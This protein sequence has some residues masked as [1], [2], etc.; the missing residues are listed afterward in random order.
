MN[1]ITTFRFS[2]ILCAMVLMCQYAIAGEKTFHA[3]ATAKVA[4][5]EG[6]V[7]VTPDE[8]KTPSETDY[9]TSSSASGKVDKDRNASSGD[10]T[11]YLFAK[12]DAGYKFSGWYNEEAC[13]SDVSDKAEAKVAF[14]SKSEK[15]DAPATKDYFAKF[16]RIKYN[17]ELTVAVV[18]GE[19]L[20]AVDK[21]ADAT[22]DYS[23]S[24]TKSITDIQDQH[25]YYIKA[26]ANSHYE[27]V[28]WYSDA[29][30]Q[31]QIAT[32]ENYT[33]S[34]EAT[35]EDEGSTQVY[36]YAKFR[37]ARIYYKSKLTV[38][39][40]GKGQVSIATSADGD[41]IFGTTLTADNEIADVDK[42]K[43]Y[44]NAR[45]N[46]ITHYF[47]GW[48]SDAE[49]KNK[50]SDDAQFAYDVQAVDGEPTGQTVYAKFAEY[51]YNSKIKV[52]ATGKGK[53]FVSKDAE[54][55]ATYTTEMS[56]SQT[57]NSTTQSYHLSALPDSDNDEFE[58]WYKDAECE[59]LISKDA[60]YTHTLTAVL[61]DAGE[62]VLY[63]KFI[64][65]EGQI[66]SKFT[67][68]AIGNGEVFVTTEEN[69][70]AAYASMSSVKKTK[71]IKT[72]Y[73][74]AQAKA[75]NYFV[76][77]YKESE[78]K[79]LLSKDAKYTHTESAAEASAS[80]TNIYAKF[81]DM[82]RS[83]V[84]VETAGNG[85]VSVRDEADGQPTFGLRQ[86]ATQSV[87]DATQVYII[88]ALPQENYTF[89]GWFAD[90]AL[91][92]KIANTAKYEMSVTGTVGKPSETTVYAKFARKESTSKMKAVAVGEGTIFVSE[93][94]SEEPTYTA[95]MERSQSSVADVHTYYF[96]A[97]GGNFRGW[98]ADEACS[99]LLS[100]QKNMEYTI[101]ATGDESEAITLYAKFEAYDAPEGSF[102]IPNSDFELWNK[103]KDEPNPGW[104]SFP[105]AVGSMAGTGKSMSPFPSQEKGRG[106]EGY[107]VK[108]YS[109]Y[110]G[111]MGIGANA[112][113]NLTTGIINMGNMDPED[114]S[115]HNYT[116]VND[117]NHHVIIAGQP[118]AFEF[119]SKFKAGT[120]NSKK[121]AHLQATIHDKYKYIDPEVAANKPHRIAS[122]SINIQESTDWVRNVQPINY[123][124]EWDF[125]KAAAT[126]KYI[127]ATFTTNQIPGGSKDDEL[128]ID[129]VR[130]IYYSEIA[131]AKYN[132]LPLTFVDGMANVKASFDESKLSVVL[133][134]RGA[135]CTQSFNPSEGL[136]TLLV[137]GEDIAVNSENYHVYTVQFNKVLPV[138]PVDTDANAAAAFETKHKDVLCIAPY[139]VTMAQKT[140]INAA[141][142]D[143]AEL[144]DRA[145][146]IV[147][148]D[149]D[150]LDAQ[151]ATIAKIEENE[152]KAAEYKTTYSNVL[153]KTSVTIA[154][155]DKGDVE[156][157][158]SAYYA[159][160]TDVKSLLETERSI[161]YSL[162]NKIDKLIAASQQ[163]GT[164]SEAQ[165]AADKFREDHAEALSLSTNNVT[166][167]DKVIVESALAAFAE[168]SDSEVIELLDDEKILLEQ[169]KQK[170]ADIE[171]E[172]AH[173]AEVEAAVNKFR[174]DNAS[175]LGKTK[176]TVATSDEQAL[177]SAL[178]AYENQTDEIK[179]ILAEEKIKLD[180]LKI[181][182]DELKIIEAIE[183][184]ATEF[185][186]NNAAA[187]AL[188]IETVK[189]NDEDIIQTALNTYDELSEEVKAK[190]ETEKELLDNLRIRIE[191]LKTAEN[192]RLAAEAFRNAHSEVLALTTESVAISDEDGIDVAV[193]EYRM[194]DIDVKALLS[195]EKDLL[196]IL[197]TKIA[198]QKEAEKIAAELN[199]AIEKFRANNA[200][201]LAL[202]V[203]TVKTTD[204]KTI[205]N[206]INAYNKLNDNAKDALSAE[207]ALLDSLIL[208]IAQIKDDKTKEEEL[209]EL[210]ARNEA[211][212]DKFKEDYTKVLDL[213]E[214]TVMV[215]HLED[216]NAALT[217]YE[218]K[219]DSVKTML[220]DEKATLDMLLDVIGT[221][222][223][224]VSEADR[225]IAN[226]F[227][228]QYGGIL[229]RTLDE[230]EGD[231]RKV[232]QKA[233][234]AFDGIS[235][236]AQS[237]LVR[238]KNKLDNFLKKIDA[239]DPI[240]AIDDIFVDKDNSKVIYDIQ[241]RRLTE[242]T[243]PG[244]YIV[245]GKKILV[246]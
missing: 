159:L 171:A 225:N 37:D 232:V 158:L 4:S 25:S 224:N 71:G 201:A 34:V 74:N 221:L 126:D 146:T 134:G 152:A 137:E 167:D 87:N 203:E 66:E 204:E 245:N 8:S 211:E 92:N 49:C 165:K 62:V 63:A 230:I 183:A 199:A 223:P 76:G 106:G 127:L 23:T 84:V 140:A 129:D 104:N 215:Y 241:G 12:P 184:A 109:K 213:N 227:R 22:P 56:A 17:S 38:S 97:D 119:Y 208:K 192:N 210:I 216:V 72:Y 95:E 35:N 1:R 128:I 175:I 186:T 70:T 19:G 169:L 18:E 114:P 58:G 86:S 102:Q 133:S 220:V 188:T 238:E 193:E 197:K 30:C 233:L 136:L 155:G 6:K 222:N 124:N 229:S 234:K 214:E 29:D 108:L 157:A 15:E 218:S 44:L 176:E 111:M 141:L 195:D 163:S 52:I 64:T 231:H 54:E 181:K 89:A 131:Q 200:A 212:A 226:K 116:D 202:T 112:N 121:L 20:V 156:N 162:M 50:L 67:A 51:E 85:K 194:L 90:E 138:K 174:T 82:Y 243:R 96:S 41:N 105:S 69:G 39:A 207:K 228:I 60:A 123:E 40:I 240:T 33:Y 73:L 170:I 101:L 148:S 205:N 53:I 190:V 237:D 99:Q 117:K 81:A 209:K 153:N 178:T 16:A 166:T 47:A 55:S 164:E 239:I 78:C 32:N 28:G 118:D 161:L 100:L 191:E 142:A 46:A 151:M 182:V 236:G 94:S 130:L 98:Y 2:A 125:A 172:N 107:A 31:T 143:Y 27:F 45:P 160:E 10:V 147:A 139:E 115:N 77:W 244:I 13:T 14:T 21:D 61:G 48:Y 103:S 91:T 120:G 5:G 11:F 189:M 93:N 173:K 24:A 242:I 198:E 185:R 36:I 122:C 26:K 144:S 80:Q 88:E 219:S 65:H 154:I 7:Y 180:D 43:Y 3:R 196:D 206:A 68:R 9:S 177:T 42:H 110:A 113:G 187:L 135:K 246:K 150:L 149:K 83:C 235:A 168:I 145:K 132:G 57:S 179:T 79:T 59:D 217:E 75:N